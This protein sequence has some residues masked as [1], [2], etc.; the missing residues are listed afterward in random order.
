[1]LLLLLQAAAHLP[2]VHSRAVA[3][4]RTCCWAQNWLRHSWVGPKLPGSEIWRPRIFGDPE[5]GP[6]T[7]EGAFAGNC[8]VEGVLL[9][10]Q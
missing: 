2:G 10:D 4:S 7:R 5:H 1:M 3:Y 8:F 6:R 9:N